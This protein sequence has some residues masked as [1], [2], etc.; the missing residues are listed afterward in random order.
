[1]IRHEQNFM[2][3]MIQKDA[4]KE[5]LNTRQTSPPLNYKKWGIHDSKSAQMAAL[6]P[7]Y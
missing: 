7:Q 4:E 6:I 1:M 2:F 5:Y 3:F